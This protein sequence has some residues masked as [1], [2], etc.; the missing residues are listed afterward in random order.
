MI[1]L[2]DYFKGRDVRYADELTDELRTNA[3]ITVDRANE[4]LRRFGESR[5]VNSG[6]RPAA[7]NANTPSAAKKSKHMLCQAVDLDDPEG[8]LDEWCWQ[9]Q[10]ELVDIDLYMEHPSATKGWCHVQIVP[11]KSQE[12][13]PLRDRKRWFYP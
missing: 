3:K 1:S 10:H 5:A 7:V 2:T 13:Y 11:P 6:W 12:K 4:L 9:N 8:D